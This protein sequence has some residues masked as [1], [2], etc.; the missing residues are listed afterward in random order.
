MTGYETTLPD[1]LL[2]PAVGAIAETVPWIV[3]SIASTVTV[4]S[5]PTDIELTSLSTTSAVTS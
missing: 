5:C 2:S 4:A 1:P 3:A